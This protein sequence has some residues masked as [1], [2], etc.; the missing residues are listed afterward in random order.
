MNANR[1]ARRRG[2]GPRRNPLEAA[3][4]R[5]AW[6]LALWL[7][8]ALLLAAGP[9]GAEVREQDSNGDGKIDR[10]VHVEGGEAVKV[11]ADTNFDGKVDL[12]QHYREGKV[13]LLERDTDHDGR[14]DTW[15]HFQD[16]HRLRQERARKGGARLTPSSTSTPRARSARSSAAARAT[17]S[18]TRSPTTRTTSPPT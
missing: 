9:A 1:L 5:R 10:W 7:L 4:A 6:A 15:D 8:L 11:E 3:P 14:T 18:S 12:V 2:A 16:G 13:S 17:A